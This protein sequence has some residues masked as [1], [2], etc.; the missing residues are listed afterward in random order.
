MRPNTYFVIEIECSG[1]GSIHLELTVACE[2]NAFAI[3]EAYLLP[4]NEIFIA[5]LGEGL[6]YGN[7]S[8]K[9][10]QARAI[11]IVAQEHHGFQLQGVSLEQA[12]A[13]LKVWLP[14]QERDT[15]L[16]WS[17]Q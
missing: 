8:F 13:V 9:V 17:E 5:C 14:H 11:N 16:T 12:L 2:V 15:R 3:V 6:D 1:V 10:S 7:L 4:G